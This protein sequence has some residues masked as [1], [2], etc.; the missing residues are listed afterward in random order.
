MPETISYKEVII[1]IIAGSLI[2]LFLAGIM[3]FILLFYQ[4][5]RF[6]HRHQFLQL[7]NSVQQELLRAQLESQEGAFRQIG[8]E[9][10]DN[11]GQLLSSTKILLAITERSLPEVP[12]TLRTASETLAQ[13]IRDLRSLSKSL[14]KEYLERFNLIENL[15]T[16]AERINTARTV[17]VEVQTSLPAM[18]LTTESQ[19]MLFR[20]VQEA[21]QNAIKHAEASS[22]R[23]HIRFEGPAIGLTITDDGKGLPAAVQRPQ[24]LGLLN[25][26]RRTHL[27]GG[28]IR[29]DSTEGSG[30][31]IQILL[32]A[33][34]LEQ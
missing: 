9:I 10:H 16:E 29:W 18:P 22:I 3:I 26:E 4:K 13:A 2:F 12:D 28:S 34:N 33:Q 6:Q 27:L 21:M 32:P 11:V 7:Q 17:S 30:T 20:I 15:R 31:R 24:G 5:K 8:E 23:I 14:T 1:V 25:M 19:I